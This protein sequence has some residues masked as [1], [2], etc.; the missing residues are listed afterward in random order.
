MY[1]SYS[2]QK[3]SAAFVA[4]VICSFYPS[5]ALESIECDAQGFDLRLVSDIELNDPLLQVLQEEIRRRKAKAH[6]RSFTMMSSLLESYSREKGKQIG[7]L[8]LLSKK[9]LHDVCEIDSYLCLLEGPHEE[10]EIKDLEIV[11]STFSSCRRGKRF[12]WHMRGFSASEKKE[13]KALASL[14]R[15]AW[16]EDAK[17]LFEREG[18][19]VFCEKNMLVLP[20]GM[21]AF[22]KM[23][24]VFCGSEERWIDASFLSFPCVNS[25]HELVSRLLERKRFMES[26]VSF[27]QDVME[28]VLVSRETSCRTPAGFLSKQTALV[29]YSFPSEP[30]FEKE[31]QRLVEVF[32]ALKLSL[33][34]RISAKNQSFI[35]QTERILRPLMREAIVLEKGEEV[36]ELKGKSCLFFQATHI[37]GRNISLAACVLE[38]DKKRIALSVPAL[39]LERSLAFALETSL[40]S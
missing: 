3:T 16:K 17:H 37:D 1:S 20:K 24:Q 34:V 4:S 21:K 28:R 27:D 7:P 13:A 11:F 2:S 38:E 9:A 15:K 6:A 31:F 40:F 39:S 8:S 12:A 25:D 30:S 22:H 36:R 14:Q 19:A 32:C 35:H 33:T 29:R 18:L 5:T 26:H 23:E 10:G